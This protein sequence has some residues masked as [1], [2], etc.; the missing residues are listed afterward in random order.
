MNREQVQTY[1]DKLHITET[2]A[3]GFMIGGFVGGAALGAAGVVL[4]AIGDPKAAVCLAVGSGISLT[5][6]IIAGQEAKSARQQISTYKAA[7]YVVAQLNQPST[8]EAE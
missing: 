5:F 1:I 7:Q 8:P 3:R 4:D 6:S 2:E